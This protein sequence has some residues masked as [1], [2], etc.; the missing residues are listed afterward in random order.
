VPARKVS[1][2]DLVLDLENPRISRAASQED[3]LQKIIEDQD[4]KLAILATSIIE[5]GGLNPMDRMLVIAGPTPGKF[6][7]IEGN[8]RLAA[9]TVLR[10]PAIMDK[11][12]VRPNLQ[13]RLAALAREFDDAATA[14]LDVWLM[15]DRPAASSWLRQRHT[16]ENQGAG[17]VDWNGVAAARF[18]GA[19]PA[20]QALDLVLKHGGL[21]DEERSDIN[22]RFPI[23]TLDRL[24][25]TPAVRA[26]IGIDVT[27][28]KLLTDLPASQIIKPL[29]RIVRDL[30]NQTIN[31]TALK[32]KEQQVAYIRGL[33]KDLPDLT[34]RT[35]EPI[36]VDA[37]TDKDFGKEKPKAQP[38]PKPKPKP[39]VR[40]TLIPSDTTLN[41]TV[42]KIAE[43]EQELRS[44]PLASYPHAISVLFRVFLEQSTDHYLGAQGISLETP[45]RGGNTNLK[46]LRT[47]VGEAIEAMIAAGT[48][49]KALDG[50]R[51]G[52]DDKNSPL[53]VDTLNSY[54]HSAF[55]SPQERELK[56]SWDNARMFFETIWA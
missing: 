18:R 21:T 20:L 1:I 10:T 23:T 22:T 17:I 48:K 5:E 51:K 46:N 3:A 41:V 43:I 28:K 34:T 8:R 6:T 7:V 9:L 36:V 49:K 47:K 31:V 14:K 37:L 50:I 29:T 11:I 52:I 56:V 16:G 39:P 4:V 30:S 25:S 13:R 44:L 55:Y 53:H 12:E 33:G 40:K 45:G 42:P 54:V 2:T 35:G 38:K 19:D 32:K 24:L 15:A 26:L 27:G